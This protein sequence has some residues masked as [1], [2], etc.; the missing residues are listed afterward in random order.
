M[1]CRRTSQGRTLK[2]RPM[3]LPFLDV[4]RTKLIA[5]CEEIDITFQTIEKGFVPTASRRNRKIWPRKREPAKNL[6]L[7]SSQGIL[8][9]ATDA[10]WKREPVQ[11]VVTKFVREGKV[12]PA[13][14]ERARL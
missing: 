10:S 5:I 7:P 8:V 11:Q 2:A 13:F 1:E 9:D 4:Y 12:D 6:E 3:W 14:E